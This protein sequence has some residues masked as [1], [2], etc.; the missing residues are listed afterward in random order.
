MST[1]PP[2]NLQYTFWNLASDF[3]DALRG[4]IEAGYA[5]NNVVF[6][7]S[8]PRT[9]QYPQVPGQEP[10]DRFILTWQTRDGEDIEQDLDQALL[11]GMPVKPALPNTDD[12]QTEWANIYE[13]ILLRI[14]AHYNHEL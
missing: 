3:E 7:L 11:D 6:G 13:Y 4:L 1:F 14:R 12:P 9:D 2:P 10:K 5:V 8:D